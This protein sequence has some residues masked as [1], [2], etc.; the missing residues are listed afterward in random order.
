MES[1]VVPQRKVQV[2]VQLL[3]GSELAGDM[4]AP[5]VGVDGEPGHLID[6]LNEE[7]VDFVVLNDG[8][9]A[10]VVHAARIL[11]VRIVGDTVEEQVKQEIEEAPL[12]RHLLVKLHLT[13]G[14]EVIGQLTYVPPEDHARLKDYLNTARRF[15]PL[16]IQKQLT[17][18]NRGQIISARALRGE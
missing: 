12:S 13:S 18:V 5:A 11:T 10:H 16:V 3:D 6:S 8:S 7:S 15:I 1:Y 17:Y 9:T 14:V 4:Y 2:Q